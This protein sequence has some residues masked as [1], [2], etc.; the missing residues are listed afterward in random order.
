MPTGD[1][2]LVQA[3]PAGEAPFVDGEPMGDTDM[4]EWP[5]EWQTAEE[6]ALALIN[7]HRRAGAVCGDE[8]FAPTTPLEM[9]ER[10]LW[11]ARLHAEDMGD[12]DYFGHDSLDGRAFADR[13]AGQG[14]R[15]DM[16]WGEN[17]AAGQNDAERV[18][19]EWMASPHHCA[20][21][22]NPKYR[23]AGIGFAVVESGEWSEYWVQD[24][25]AS[26]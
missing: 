5:G 23:V 18:V 24:F 9:N 7:E 21:I 15:G 17:I 2:S 14:F 3:G 19:R 13:I 22:M 8:E 4:G 16:P 6:A 10:L 12:Q 1:D 26:H 11:A 25:A 20:N